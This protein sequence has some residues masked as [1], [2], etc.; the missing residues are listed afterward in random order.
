MTDTSRP[1]TTLPAVPLGPVLQ[2]IEDMRQPEEGDANMRFLA[3]GWNSQIDITVN[4]LRK[5]FASDQPWPIKWSVTPGS[6]GDWLG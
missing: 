1:A 6:L 3:R 4:M 5:R 2:A